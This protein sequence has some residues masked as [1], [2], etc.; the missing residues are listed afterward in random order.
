MRFHPL[1]PDAECPTCGSGLLFVRVRGTGDLYHCASGVCKCQVM[2][3][4]NKQYKTCRLATIYKSGKFGE[5]TAC[6]ERPAA[7]E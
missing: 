7:K 1:P 2:H 3:Y 4:G 6:G 5:W